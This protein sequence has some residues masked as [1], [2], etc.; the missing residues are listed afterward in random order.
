[1]GDAA[2][3][4]S[5]TRYL[6]APAGVTLAAVSYDGTGFAGHGCALEVAGKVYCWGQGSKGEL[7]YTSPPP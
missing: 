7:G 1:M 2:G 5:A 6:Y 3:E 4:T